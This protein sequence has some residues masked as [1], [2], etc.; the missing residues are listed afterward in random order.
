M[1][2]LFASVYNPDVLS[3]LANLSNDEVFTP[4]ELANQVL[5]MLP[6][7]IWLSTTAKFLDP[8]SKSGVFL[9]EIAKRLIRGQLPDFEYRTAQIDAKRIAGE[10]LDGS[11]EAYLYRLQKVL[12]HIFHEQIYGIG[13]TELTALMSRRSLY[14]SKWANSPYSVV[15]FSDTSGNIRFKSL[16]HAWEGPKGKEKCKWCGA[17]RK[18]IEENRTSDE[19]YAYELIHTQ[20]PERIYPDMQFDV[21]V[22]NP[23][24]QVNDG[25]GTGSS[26]R[27]IYQM[28]IQ[29]AMKLRPRYLSMIVPA[30]WYSGG[31]GLDVFRASMLADKRMK[32]L[33]TYNDSRECF[34]GV[35]IAGGVCYFLWS[36]D[37][38]GLCEMETHEPLGVNVS[39]R[40]LDEYPVLIPGKTAVEIIR[41]V[42]RCSS[43]FFDAVVRP[44]R[45]F[46][47]GSDFPDKNGDFGYRWRGGLERIDSNRV[48]SGKEMVDKW[49]VII[50]KAAAEHAGQTDKQ[51]LRKMLTVIEVLPPKTVCSETYLVVD[52]FDSEREAK[53]LAEYLRTRFV[54][55]LIWQATPTQNISKGC[56]MFVPWLDDGQAVDDKSL[57]EYFGLTDEETRYIEST[58]KEFPV[59]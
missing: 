43:Q 54:R 27:P 50:S 24:Y 52:A 38:Q 26:A 12:D 59:K 20:R 33:V 7:S 40:A 6:E 32:K 23:P 41:K 19:T 45:P 13:I 8:C 18:E 37:E 48:V 16:Q 29:Q 44:R 22:G 1:A 10:D 21:I 57:Y 11:D 42:K 56:F 3:C 49:K 4:P 30:R 34:N 36:R 25:G 5:N 14:C 39:V 58:I 55:F 9:R 51:G 47:I 35:D 31:K 17:T 46:G 2:D 15:Q 53:R 28:F